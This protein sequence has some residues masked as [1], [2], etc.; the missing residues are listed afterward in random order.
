MPFLGGMWA[1]SILV[2]SLIVGD[3]K[4]ND[5]GYGPLY[6]PILGPFITLGTAKTNFSYDPAIG[7]FLVLD[8]LAQAGG[9]ALLITGIV[10]D[11]K[12]FVRDST[13]PGAPQAPV[14]PTG[15][16]PDVRVG[17]GSASLGW[18]F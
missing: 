12:V 18:T 7:A 17:L 3:N 1:F 16:V 9:A 8:G 6:A 13:S 14:T 11:K 15:L 5:L 4:G 10:K 2:A